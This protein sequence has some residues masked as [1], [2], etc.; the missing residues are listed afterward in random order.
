MLIKRFFFFV[1]H[2]AINLNGLN[3]IIHSIKRL[4]EVIFD[5]NSERESDKDAREGRQR[6]SIS[7]AG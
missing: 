2:R 5:L 3:N 4:R 6:K 7:S 1:S